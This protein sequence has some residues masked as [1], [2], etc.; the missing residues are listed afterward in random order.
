MCATPLPLT[1]SVVPTLLELSRD[2][3]RR[4]DESFDNGGEVPSSPK[5]WGRFLAGFVLACPDSAEDETVFY[6]VC[7]VVYARDGGFMFVAPNFEGLKV[8]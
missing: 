8:I 3:L 1:P 2:G 6:V 5:C 7:N 4:R